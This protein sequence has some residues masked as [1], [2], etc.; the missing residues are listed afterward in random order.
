MEAEKG[1]GSLTGSKRPR[2]NRKLPPACI[3]IGLGLVA[4]HVWNEVSQAVFY[5]VC[6]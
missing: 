5:F 3:W 6:L 4:V 2:Q 1:R